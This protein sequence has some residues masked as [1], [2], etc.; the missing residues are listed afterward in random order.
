MTLNPNKYR[1]TLDALKPKL[2]ELLPKDLHKGIVELA[3]TSHVPI[4]ALVAYA[5]RDDV[6]GPRDELKHIDSVNRKFYGYEII[7]EWNDLRRS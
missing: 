3:V 4:Q 1:K 7:N 2:L 5:L 6:L